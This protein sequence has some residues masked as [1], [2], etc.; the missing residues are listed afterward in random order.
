M[1]M[2]RRIGAAV[3]GLA[4][5]ACGGGADWTGT[6]TDSA[7]VAIVQNAENP[8][9][10]ESSAWTLEEELSIG[11]TE[12]QPEYQFGQIGTVAVGSDGRLFVM[13]MQGQHVKVFTPDGQFD[14]TIGGPGAGP[15]EIGAG[16]VFVLVGVG[17]T[18][19][20]PDM[21]NR[22]INRYGPDGSPLTSSP[23]EIEK[24]LPMVFQ[25]TPSGTIAAQVRSLS[26]PNRPAP[27]TLDRIM[28][29][30]SDGT[31]G[32]TL[33]EFPSGGT[34]DFGGGSPEI[35]LYSPEP[36][37]DLTDDLRVLYGINDEYRIGLYGT[38]GE[39]QRVIT[40]PFEREPVSDND[41]Q[42]VMTALERAWVDAGVPPQMLPQLRTMVHFAE[43]FP[44]FS[45]VQ[46]GPRGSIW[47][48]HVQSAAGL[49]EEELAEFNVMED[50][51]S[52]DWDVFDADGR[53]LGIVSMPP[54]F[55]PR[56]FV[57]DRIFGVWRN[58]LDVQFA[59]Q[60]R[61]VGIPGVEG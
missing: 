11:E 8:I 50:T 30:E 26:L 46:V 14:R 48:Q 54:R 22:R 60:L 24:G 17:D 13:D 53:F 45:S 28:L 56:H 59:M 35:N 29:L 19:F 10:T 1:S 25:A 44:A 7:G 36:A 5:A 49:T 15:G 3:A 21:A 33:L 4:I 16:A 61:V 52:P 41:R 31:F 32:D 9:W 47:V 51:G 34:L 38:E 39:L 2:A 57:G 27:D 18:V 37:W 58:E 55:Q 40:M 20:V 6:V 43:F 23:L 42:A 12:G